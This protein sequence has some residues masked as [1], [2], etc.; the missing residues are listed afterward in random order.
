GRR[1][2]GANNLSAPGLT[3]GVRRW[4]GLS[5]IVMATGL[6]SIGVVYALPGPKPGELHDVLVHD[7]RGGSPLPPNVNY[8]GAGDTEFI[9]PE[10]EGTRITLPS[11]YIHPWG[12]VGFNAVT[13]V[14]G[15]FE[16]TATVE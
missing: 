11:T 13:A 6:A 3:A 4:L 16:I 1:A 9:K 5:A 7:F 2:E 10:P 15:D 14:G 8:F 12:G